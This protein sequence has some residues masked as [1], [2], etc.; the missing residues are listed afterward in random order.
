MTR[1]SLHR[2][3]LNN[4]DAH[5]V[6]CDKQLSSYERVTVGCDLTAKQPPGCPSAVP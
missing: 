3:W 4:L 6:P 5:F 1:A 2:G